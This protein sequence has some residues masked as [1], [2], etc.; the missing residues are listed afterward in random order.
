MKQIIPLILVAILM[1]AA[2]TQAAIKSQ[3][4]DYK[5]GD[6]QLQGY[7]AYDDSQPGTKPGVLVIPEWWGLTDYARHRAD[8]LA[9]LGYV[10]FAADMYGKGITTNDPNEAGKL[11]GAFYKNR[12]LARSRAGAGLA[13]LKQQPEVNA[14]KIA[15]IG[16]CF[17]GTAALELARGG[18]DILGVVSFHGGLDFENDADNKNIKA[19][20]L[21]CTGAE[22]PMVTAD[23]VNKFQEALRK[24]DVDFQI[25]TYCKAKHAFTNPEADSHNIPGI[26]Y[27]A[28][29]DER[30]WQAMKDF[31]A[32]IFK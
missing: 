14:N 23:K 31:F 1:N 19:K 26:S 20:L 3:A 17:G 27:N 15:V 24:A 32:E 28:Q 7:L 21:I 6:V 25:N 5:D 30:S 4:I 18:A 22:D 8:Q 11:A 29:A 9:K 12:N 16:Y 10:A 2:T 13:V